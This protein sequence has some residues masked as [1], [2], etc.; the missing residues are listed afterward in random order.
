MA[1]D[2]QPSLMSQLQVL[3]RLSM[4]QKLGLMVA[5]AAIIAIIVG[6]WL[7]ET[8]PDYRVLYS[9]LSDQD[10]GAIIASLQQMN[11]PYKFAEG[12]GA[13][14]VPAD[15]VHETRLKLATQGLPK[16]SLVGFELLDNEKFG[17]SQFQE[18]VNYQRA[19]EGEL[20]R[21]IQS[22][23]PVQSA[24]VHLAIPKPSVFVRDQEKPSASVLLNLY[25]GKVLDPSQVTA[26]A[27]LVSSSVPE[28]SVKNVTIVDQ[29]GNLLSQPVDEL[30][31]SGMNPGQLKYL[32][33]TEKSYIK[34]IE[35]I[36]TPVVG[37]NNVRAQVT[38]DL[39]FSQ[40]ENTSE[41]Y[42]PNQPPNAAAVRSEQ[43]S[44]TSSSSEQKANGVPGSLSNQPPAPV[45]APVAAPPNAA[46][47]ASTKPTSTSGNTAN[48]Q[49]DMTTNYEVDKTIQ[50]V[51]NQVGGIKR[52]SVGVVVNYEKVVDPKKKTVT[53]KPLPSSEIKQITDLV[54]DTMGFDATRGDTL[55]VVNAA[56]TAPEVETIPPL[57]WYKQ[58]GLISLATLIGKNLAIAGVVLY[59]LLGVIRPALRNIKLDAAAMAEAQA[60][61]AAAEQQHHAAHAIQ[62]TE[63][64]AEA[65]KELARQNPQLVANVIKGWVSGNE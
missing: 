36:L 45:S 26:I 7:W 43:I 10:G 50:H 58:P 33:D 13:L 46:S 22:L 27:H 18:Q 63:D 8:T 21:T 56:F 25:P 61:V 6:A 47:T 11:V 39:D 38:A 15:K 19:L 23:S 65:A 40:V 1:V 5:V 60:A 20:A 49:K 57:P 28:L 16:G 62:T 51:K 17:T 29:N 48:M 59:L 35:D 9:N 32:Q 55:N 42:K 4:Q 12:G 53:Y 34:R 3:S 54:K 44:E 14:L 2:D 64:T 31:A 30:L 41:T 24:R 37:A 52:L